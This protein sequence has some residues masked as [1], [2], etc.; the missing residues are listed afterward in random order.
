LSL[1]KCL[2]TEEYNG[3]KIIIEGAIFVEAIYIIP[4]LRQIKKA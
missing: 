2:T 1:L 4:P 3:V